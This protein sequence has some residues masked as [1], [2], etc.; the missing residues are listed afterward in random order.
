MSYKIMLKSNIYSQ[1]ENAPQVITVDN[2]V[3]QNN[4]I[5]VNSYLIPIVNILYIKQIT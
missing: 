1:V 3:F 2:L 4:C 5:V